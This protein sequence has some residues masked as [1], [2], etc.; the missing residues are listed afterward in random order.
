MTRSRGMS[1]MLAIFILSYRLK[2]MTNS[3]VLHCFFNFKELFISPQPDFQLRWI[4]D[5]SVAL[6][7]QAI[8]TEKSK[9]D[10]A[11]M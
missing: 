3:N 1:W 7:G 9:L 11:D 8:Y 2:E 4:L 5:Q 6:N 10:I